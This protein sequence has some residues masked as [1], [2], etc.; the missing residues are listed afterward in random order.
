MN[1]ILTVVFFSQPNKVHKLFKLARHNLAGYTEKTG[2]KLMRDTLAKGVVGAYKTVQKAAWAAM[3]SEVTFR[4]IDGNIN[5]S[6][7]WI[8]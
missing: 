5:V 4:I 2:A 8:K 3:N 6:D 7:M 1:S